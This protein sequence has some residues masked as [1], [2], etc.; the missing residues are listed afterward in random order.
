MLAEKIYKIQKEL[1]EKR[2]RRRA[3]Q[4]QPPGPGGPGAGPGQGPMIPG[5]PQLQNPNQPRPEMGMP[6]GPRGPNPMGPMRPMGPGAGLASPPTMGTRMPTPPSNMPN[7]MFTQPNDSG[8]PV[9]GSVLQKQLEQSGPPGLRP[10]DNKSTHLAAQLQGANAGNPSNTPGSGSSLL[11]HSLAK[12][13][14]SDPNPDI[15]N[16]VAT[17]HANKV[18]NDSLHPILSNR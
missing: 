2:Q 4:G 18:P 5:Q 13:T 14:T 3:Q 10:G 1:E 8:M 7:Q 16:K 9:S 12:P 11:L 6:G 15:I 17:C